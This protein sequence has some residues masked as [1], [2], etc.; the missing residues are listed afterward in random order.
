[1]AFAPLGSAPQGLDQ[2]ASDS[3]N[4]AQPDP[5]WPDPARLVSVPMASDSL[6]PARP[7][8]A[9]VI[10]APDRAAQ[11]MDMPVA[12][13]PAARLIPPLQLPEVPA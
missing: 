2:M 10:S 4:P 11:P 1:M 3:L 6:N 13:A 12:C 7:D 9:L 8:F 5:A